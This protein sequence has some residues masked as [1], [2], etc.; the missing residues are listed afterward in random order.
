[1]Y[2]GSINVNPSWF[3]WTSEQTNL[4]ISGGTSVMLILYFGKEKIPLFMV[5]K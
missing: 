2:L 4:F 5:T 1:M 3:L